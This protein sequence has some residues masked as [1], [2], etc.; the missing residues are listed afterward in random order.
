MT[1]LIQMS[2]LLL[3]ALTL[4]LQG[5]ITLESA[6]LTV[7][8]SGLTVLCP[9]QQQQQHLFSHSTLTVKG[10]SLHSAGL[11]CPAVDLHRTV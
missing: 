11:F 9:V 1:Q 7:Q 8:T 2:Q 10:H 5:L 3:T 4:L 6:V